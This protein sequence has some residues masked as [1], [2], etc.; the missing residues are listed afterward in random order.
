VSATFNILY[1]NLDETPPEDFR[2]G[3]CAA[4]DRGV[5]ENPFGVEETTIPGGRCAVLRHV[6]SDDALGEAVRYLYT[7]WLPASGE[8]PRA[9]PPLSPAGPLLPGRARARGGRRHFP[10]SRVVRADLSLGLDFAGCASAH[11]LGPVAGASRRP[12]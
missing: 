12:G 1:D 10:A 4:T 9:F 3:L 6:G 2:F 11:F 7:T 8:K 5:T